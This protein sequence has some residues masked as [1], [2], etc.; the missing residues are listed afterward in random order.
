MR[1]VYNTCSKKLT[2][3]DFHEIFLAKSRE[4]VRCKE[5]KKF[6]KKK[7]SLSKNPKTFKY[8]ENLT[9]RFIIGAWNKLLAVLTGWNR[10]KPS[11]I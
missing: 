7:V 8:W 6:A 4:L 5:P 11:A 1:L 10:E 2:K 9:R 3:K